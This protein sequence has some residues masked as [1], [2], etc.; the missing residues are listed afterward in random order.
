MPGHRLGQ[1]LAVDDHDGEDGAGLDRDVE[2]LALVVGEA[3]QRAGEDQV[4]GARDRQEFGQAFDDPHDRGLEQHNEIQT[5]PSER[6]R[7]AML[8]GG[9]GQ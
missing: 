8:A 2:D 3:E 1:A 4:A 6:E 9:V 7:P 5:E